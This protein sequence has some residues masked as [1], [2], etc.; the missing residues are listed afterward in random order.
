ME[1][2]I[3]G[4]PALL[5][6]GAYMG[7]VVCFVLA[8][9]VWR[10][11]GPVYVR[12]WQALDHDYGRV[13]PVMLLPCLLLLVAMS[14]LS[15]QRGAL[16][17]TLALAA[18]VLLGLAVAVTL[19]QMEP[20]NRVADSWDPDHLPAGW[21]SVRDQWLRWHFLRTGLSVAAFLCVLAWTVRPFRG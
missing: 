15:W 11:P 3:I 2:R 16:A 8:P 4:V 6:C 20:L 21:T 12:Y 5:L 18:T 19:T 14:A 1:T 9:S 10:L 13:M 17:L 7:G